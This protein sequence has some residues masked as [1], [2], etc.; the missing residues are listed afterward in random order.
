MKKKLSLLLVMLV[1]IAAF[2]AQAL[3]AT[4]DGGQQ[5]LKWTYDG[6]TTAL[7]AT[8]SGTGGSVT[9][10]NSGT[11]NF[12]TESAAYV[13]KIADD[14]APNKGLK[15][16]KNTQYLEVTLASG[17]FKAGDQ[18][19][20][21]GYNEFMFCTEAD[22]SKTI[23]DV[24][25]GNDKNNY[26]V[27]T[28]T[29]PSTFQEQSTLYLFRK[30]GSSTAI[31]AMLVT[32][33]VSSQVPAA[34]V[35]S[36]ANG[37]IDGLSKV[38]ITS[39]GASTIYY[40]WSETE[41]APATYESATAVGGAITVKAPDVTGTRYLYAYGNNTVGDG[42][43]AHATYS[44]TKL[45]LDEQ[46][47]VT[48]SATWDWS[49][50]GTTEIVLT[51]ETKP[52]KDEEF[53]LSNVV[54]YGFCESIGADF[55]NAQQLLV[56]CQYPVRNG[57]FFQGPTVKF[58]T[59]VAGKVKV[60]FCSTGNS[61]NRDLVIN[62][63]IAGNS[64][65]T[66]MTE[67]DE[68]EVPAG[69]VVIKG[70]THGEEV[71]SNAQYMRISKIEFTETAP[72]PVVMPDEA[73][74]WSIT[75][76]MCT[77]VQ[78]D[79]PLTG[80]TAK[81]A[82]EESGDVYMQV[83]V[84]SL[85]TVTLKGRFNSS[86]NLVTFPKGQAAS[87]NGTTVYLMGAA[88]LAGEP[89]DIEFLLDET[90]TT[91]TQHRT[92]IVASTSK[93]DINPVVAFIQGLK[94]KKPAD[95]PTEVTDELTLAT[96]GVTGNNYADVSGK[97][98]TSQAIYAAN[99]A[100]GNDAIQLRSNNNN[101]GIITTASGG[102]V[103]SIKIEWNS[104]TVDARV[105]DV[106][107]KTSAYSSVSDLY[108]S[109]GQG[110]KIA[111]FTK[112]EGTQTVTIEGDYQYIGFRSRSGAMYIDKI[113]IVWDASSVPEPAVTTPV[114]SG[115]T[116]FVG[117][118]E[119]TITCETEGAKIYYTT[120][121]TD[122]TTTS[123][124]YTEAFTITETTTV[125]AIAAKD[126]A[127]SEIV[128][129][130]FTAVPA[131][132]TLA[133]A[134]ALDNNTAFAFTGNLLVIA[135]PTNQYV[136]VE[137][138]NASGL[139]YDQS[140]TKTADLGL[141]TTIA[142]NWIGHI[143]IY[144]ALVE[145][146]PDQVLANNG[147]SAQQVVYESV[148]PDFIKLEN[149]N[150]VVKLEDVTYVAPEGTNKNFSIYKGDAVVP[151]YNQ[152]GLEIADAEEGKTYDIVG[153][154]SRYNDN[155]QFQPI[156]IEEHVAGPVE[157]TVVDLELNLTDN[158]YDIGTVVTDAIAE[159]VTGGYAMGDLTV[160]LSAEYAYTTT[161][162]IVAPKNVTI[163]GNGA[164]VN[165]SGLTTP[166]IQMATIA[167]GTPVN[168]KGAYVIDGITIKNVTI[169]GLPY[170]LIYGNTQKYL[171]NKIL[172]DN[173]VIGINGT[174]KKT[175][176]DFNGGG[177][178]SEIIID[179]STLWAN[180]SNEQN[181]GLFSSQS[182]HGSIQDLGSDKQLF[183]ITNSTIYNIAYGKTTNTQRRNSTAGMEYKVEN[184]AIVN[185]GKSGQFIVGLN[186][187]SANS[188]QTYTI[189]NNI[190]NFDGADVSAAE[191]TKVREKIADATLNSVA[192]IIAFTSTETP[193]FGGTFT[194]A[195]GASAPETAIGDPRWSITFEEA[196]ATAPLYIIGGMNGWNLDAMTEM[197]FNAETQAY[198]YTYAPTEKDYF[199]FS[200]KQF[201][202]EEAADEQAWELFNQNNRYALTVSGNQIA[203]LNTALPLV[204]ATGGGTIVVKPVK[205][206]TTYKIS[207]AKDL[208]T[209]TIAGESAPEPDYTF[210]VAGTPAEIF[211]TEWDASNQ[212]NLMEKQNDG[213]YAKTYT[214]D[215]A[216]ES[217][218]LKVVKDGS[219]WIGD[220]YGQNVSFS[221]FDA[222]S[223][224]VTIDPETNEITVTGDFVMVPT[225]F[226]YSSVYAVGNG[227][228]G[229]LNGQVWTPNAEA[230]KMTKVDGADDVW[231]ITFKGVPATPEGG[232]WYQ[233]KFA[234]DGS[235]DHNF[236]G[237]FA[238]FG[239]ATAAAYNGDNI[240][241]ALTEASDVT[242]RLDLTNFDIST[243]Q[244]A[245]F[246][247]T[248]GG[249]E[250]PEPL[251]GD[252]IAWGAD[253]V[254]ASAGLDG[255]TYGS[256]DFLLTL[257][258][259][260]SKMSVD[261]NS[262]Y[263]GDATQQY[264]FTHR[265]KTGGKSQAASGMKLTIAKAGELEVYVRSGS[266]SATDRNLVLKQNGTEIFN[267]IVKDE[268][269]IEVEKDALNVLN[270]TPEGQ[271][272]PSNRAEST[273]V[274]VFPAI[275]VTVA[276]GEV[277]VAYPVN[278]LNFYAFCFKA[279]ATGIHMV[280][281]AKYGEG[282][283]YTMQGVEILQP[284]KK[285]LYIHNGR[286]VVVK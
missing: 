114:I 88:S 59:T 279:A 213:T 170:Q 104:N 61:N 120:D 15:F 73:E 140:G 203:T 198:E 185:S 250:E 135:K 95:E 101:S 236:G 197:T 257:T 113:T 152:F 91:L 70:I 35:F 6:S 253:D 17:N 41:T 136:Y 58:K 276:A 167:E 238:A 176:F 283:W 155:V 151:G 53:I 149:V 72:E 26:K 195:E 172:V 64:T 11:D 99:L 266:G 191:E 92:Y 76:G 121:G 13:E 82:F 85:A 150:Q 223:F 34:P 105:L 204:K 55:G 229:W 119:V 158:T 247:I 271:Q 201:T 281:A 30:N 175:I 40:G 239:E 68:V 218:E 154:I 69:D 14:M 161:K 125:K 54:K 111:S 22:R 143:S 270:E 9:L 263:F 242:L 156:T 230:N 189:N 163:N 29:L 261:A 38:L 224:T 159:V 94:L 255:K 246:T 20:I 128:T 123:T 93:N 265:L 267:Q 133:A 180:P 168:D 103:M 107:G 259:T 277:E 162:S 24:S 66:S 171:M 18:I 112:S 138:E 147:A 60:T 75:E 36:P 254:T 206:A 209:V 262:Q 90:Q 12:S 225:G 89:T 130:K 215:K 97:K 31:A 51:A 221:L 233:V 10:K 141:G 268:D 27:G 118:T 282:K 275:K 260:N 196:A 216:Y 139:I 19:T 144:H 280:N 179:K 272:A 227:S 100:G 145:M 2:A 237:T 47:D 193:D 117:E 115:E 258:D 256:E 244:G 243:K 134:N 208:S 110:T 79:M 48:E 269:A 184:S 153:A 199:V 264:K 210:I 226:D 240:A 52:K 248:L 49:K 39:D 8:I 67:S 44:I 207:V 28:F 245:K 234:I 192:G 222:G 62:S 80:Q 182:G 74:D 127:L 181:G 87:V 235:W 78:T 109:E 1:A 98:A 102:T 251:E 129:K 186:G 4:G 42:T 96:F 57:Q 25:T 177:N 274:K 84:A 178:A 273:T 46:V 212:A 173:C 164:T 63:T 106:Y 220:A 194:L 126:D 202:A 7:D 286:T 16:G 132:A 214:V 169:T 160:N 81:V 32:R 5:V 284:T 188:A 211:G 50:F 165:A 232:D 249:G 65:S 122:P 86:S 3:R 183:A 124:E 200:D 231:E 21:C 148:E 33:A 190:F 219:Q 116:P 142:A 187:G 157:P 71:S 241:F 146:V 228:E 43:L 205:E 77:V 278:S 108:D 174:A 37:A 137:D 56:A 23:G 45:V 83:S 252:W 166:F 131:V 285:G 217:V